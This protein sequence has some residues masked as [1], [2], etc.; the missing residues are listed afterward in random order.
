VNVNLHIERL[1][2]DG[3]SAG[4]DGGAAVRD[5][6]QAELARLF[7]HEPALRGLRANVAVP[8]LRGEPVDADARSLGASVAKS[9]Y[10]AVTR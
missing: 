2:L 7:T 5:A 6:I 8:S 3:M 1:L 10:G 9:V 4:E